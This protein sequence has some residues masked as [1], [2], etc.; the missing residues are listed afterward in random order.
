VI[1]SLSQF[2]DIRIGIGIQEEEFSR[3]PTT[4]CLSQ[5]YPNPFN[6][7]TDIRYQI[8]YSRSPVHATLKIYNILGQEVRTL[9]DEYQD[10]GYYSVTWNGMDDRGNSMPSGVYSYRLSVNS[11]KWSD[12]RKMVLVK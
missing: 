7:K 9:V 12:V 2:F 1:D 10:G 5:N 8:A 4:F 11:G 3:V 6:P